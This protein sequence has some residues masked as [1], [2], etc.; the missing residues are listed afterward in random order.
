MFFLPVLWK[1]LYFFLSDWC[2]K[3]NI[4][5]YCI[6]SFDRNPDVGI[7]MIGLFKQYFIDTDY[8]HRS[9]LIQ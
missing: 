8:I 5:L 2:K 4:L 9:E 3:K 7:R 1:A 6:V